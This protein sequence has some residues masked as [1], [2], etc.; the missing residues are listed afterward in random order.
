M[1]IKI[2]SLVIVRDDN[3]VELKINNEYFHLK[4]MDVHE[5]RE[6]AEEKHRLRAIKK[7]EEAN[8]LRS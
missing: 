5:I 4:G 1:T 3:S 2:S 6:I 7:Q 8:A